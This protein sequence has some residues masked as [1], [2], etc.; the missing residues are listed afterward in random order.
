M[1]TENGEEPWGGKKGP[2]GAG[3]GGAELMSGAAGR[4]ESSFFLLS[5]P[6]A[7]KRVELFFCRFRLPICRGSL[8]GLLSGGVKMF[9]LIQCTGRPILFF[10]FPVIVVDVLC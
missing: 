4:D 2:R 3:E 6:S 1:R 8:L 10:Y 5:L 7:S 9:L